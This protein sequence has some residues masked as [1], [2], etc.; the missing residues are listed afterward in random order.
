ML[1]DITSYRILVYHMA[2]MATGYSICPPRETNEKRPG[3][4]T[5]LIARIVRCIS[6]IVLVG[7]YQKEEAVSY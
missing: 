4:V 6:L 7:Q 5:K 2:A 3:R 1:I